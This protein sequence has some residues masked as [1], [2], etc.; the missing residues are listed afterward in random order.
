MSENIRGSGS[1]PLACL[2]LR[3]LTYIAFCTKYGHNFARS[4]AEL[5][6]CVHDVRLISM[7]GWNEPFGLVGGPNLRTKPITGHTPDQ[8][9]KVPLFPPDF[10]VLYCVFVLF[11][12]IDRAYKADD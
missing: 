2:A 7:L 6:L 1:I 11:F 12:N 4:S 5:P 3:A 9:Q 8:T 10:G